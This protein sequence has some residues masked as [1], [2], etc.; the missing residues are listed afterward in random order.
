MSIS[1]NV[2]AQYEFVLRLTRSK[3]KRIWRSDWLLHS[4]RPIR[5]PNAAT[6]RSLMTYVVFELGVSAE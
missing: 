4:S 3:R 6:F 1:C 2:K 5:A